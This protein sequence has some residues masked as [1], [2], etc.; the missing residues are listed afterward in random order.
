MTQFHKRRWLP[1]PPNAEVIEGEARQS[2]PRR[3]RGLHRFILQQPRTGTIT[4]LVLLSILPQVR[5]QSVSVRYSSEN[6]SHNSNPL[7]RDELHAQ[8]TT[9]AGDDGLHLQPEEADVNRAHS[10][11]QARVA[12]LR[13][14]HR[15][16][17]SSV[18]EAQG[19]TRARLT[20]T[21]AVELGRRRW[22]RH[23]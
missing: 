5:D 12:E 13:V 4:F 2:G 22:S 21:R 8:L 14:A 20:M 16:R 1:L 11:T 23:W 18:N 3:G 9:G 6:G 15:P 17:C 10:G 19:S 7:A